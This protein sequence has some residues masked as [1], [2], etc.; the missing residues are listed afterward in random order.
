MR[1]VVIIFLDPQ[2]DGL[3]C[4]VEALILVDPC[5][6]FYQAAVEAFDVAVAFGMVVSGAA[7]LDAEPVEG[8]DV[9]R[10]GELRAVNGGQGKFKAARAVGQVSEHRALQCAERFARATTQA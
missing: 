10:R 8:F 2:G 9:A 5:L 3:L 1:T 6:L 7:V 4:V